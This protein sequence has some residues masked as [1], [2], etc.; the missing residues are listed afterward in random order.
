[1][2]EGE[3]SIGDTVR[4]LTE[5]YQEIARGVVNFA[6]QDV[7]RIKGLRTEE[8]KKLFEESVPEEVIH[9]DNMVLMI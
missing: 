6:E 7:Q 1:F 5:D 3:Y 2:S 4:V 9:R 8:F